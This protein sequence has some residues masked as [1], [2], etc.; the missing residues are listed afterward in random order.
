MYSIAPVSSAA[1]LVLWPERISVVTLV[2]HQ[3]DIKDSNRRQTHGTSAHNAHVLL[4]YATVR[5]DL[6][7]NCG[8]EVAKTCDSPLIFRLVSLEAVTLIGLI[9]ALF[10]K[11]KFPFAVIMSSA[12]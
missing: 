7:Y 5:I 12:Y 9:N 6:Y 1:T 3:E 2:D 11:T 10:V 4:Q 8:V